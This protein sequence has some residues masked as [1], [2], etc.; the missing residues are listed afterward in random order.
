MVVWQRDFSTENRRNSRTQKVEYTPFPDR[1]QFNRLL[2]PNLATVEVEL[3]TLWLSA[4]KW[5]CFR[6]PASGSLP[7]NGHPTTLCLMWREEPWT[8]AMVWGTQ[9]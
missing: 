3:A 9:T 7:M 2:R 8:W 4:L 6:T 5:S 1:E